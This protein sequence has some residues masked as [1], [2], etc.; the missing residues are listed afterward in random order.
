MRRAV[1]DKMRCGFTVCRE[2]KRMATLGSVHRNS[3]QYGL[4]TRPEDRTWAAPGTL[5]SPM[6]YWGSMVEIES[7][8][9]ARRGEQLRRASGGPPQ[10]Q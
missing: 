1:N 4:V 2:Q 8:W 7:R 3:V 6:G 5:P 10:C 9:T